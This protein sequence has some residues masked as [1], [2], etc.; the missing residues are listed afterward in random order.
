[1]RVRLDH[2]LTDRD[3]RRVSIQLLLQ[4]PTEHSAKRRPG[5]PRMERGHHGQVEVSRRRGCHQPERGV[6]PPVDMDD[7]YFPA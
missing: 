1:M 5:E 7:S 4:Q 2:R 3:C 6:E